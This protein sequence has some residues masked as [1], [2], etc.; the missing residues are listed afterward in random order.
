MKKLTLEDAQHTAA[1]YGGMC[2]SIFLEDRLK[3]Q[4]GKGHQ[5]VSSLRQV[6]HYKSWCPYC[7]GIRITIEDAHIVAKQKGGRCL[8]EG[9]TH[10]TTITKLK[11]ECEFGHIW[12][13]KFTNVKYNNTW[14]PHCGGTKRLT[15]ECMTWLA[16]DQGW[17]FLS[18][19]YEPRKKLKWMC[20]KGHL[21]ELTA[22]QVIHDKSWCKWCSGRF[23]YTLEDLKSAAVSRGGECLASI[24][25]GSD[26]LLWKCKMG[27]TWGAQAFSVL[28]NRTWCPYCAHKVPRSMDEIREVAAK[29]GGQCLSDS[30]IGTESP[31]RW[32]C[33]KGHEWE[34][35]P[36][37]VLDAGTWCP[38]CRVHRT[39][40]ICREV[41]EA[42]FGE[43]FPKLKPKWLRN[44][45]GN[46]M[47]L[48]GYCEKLSIAFEYQG[49]QHYNR[50]YLHKA[51]RKHAVR[52]KEE[53]AWSQQKDQ[54]KRELCESH[55]VILVE[56]PW[57][58]KKLKEAIPAALRSKG[59][60]V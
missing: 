17:T 37:S 9:V 45:K 55:G 5:W 19:C 30:W 7:K 24:Y 27:H 12:E 60:L 3:W 32:K 54:E 25:S 36:H 10:I 59:I 21:F 52:T 56:I 16:R 26:K 43:P 6:R 47:E 50:F 22:A 48:D 51:S 31:M 13:T 49:E 18:D 29:H 15:T 8:S 38:H 44:S 57:Y 58:T 28:K 20:A 34:A 35:T 4:C 41:F 40:I 1:T 53:F 14:C 33:K 2:V 23:K 11:W 42:L 46:L 39:E